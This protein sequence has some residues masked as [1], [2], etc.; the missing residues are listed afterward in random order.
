[1]WTFIV[2]VYF[3]HNQNSFDDYKFCNFLDKLTAFIW[4]FTIKNGGSSTNKL[5]PPL[6]KEMINIVNDRDVA[7]SDD[8]FK[9]DELLQGAKTFA[10]L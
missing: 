6:Y 4:A 1:M 7:F 2:S 3:L 5:R 8:K 9:L 10:A